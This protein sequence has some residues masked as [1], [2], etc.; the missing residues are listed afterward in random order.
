MPS[1]LLE[2]PISVKELYGRMRDYR[3]FIFLTVYLGLISLTV[4]FLYYVQTETYSYSYNRFNPNAMQELGKAIFAGVFFAELLL[5]NLVS[6]G[7]TSNAITAERERRTLDLLKITLLTPRSIITGKLLPSVVY[8]LL[9]VF[10][11]LPIQSAAFLLGGV[12]LAE[13]I[14]STLILIV[15]GVYLCSLGIFLSSGIKKSTVATVISYASIPL[16]ILLAFAVYLF[17][18]SS[19]PP[20]DINEKIFVYGLWVFVSINPFLAAIISELILVEADSLYLF[21]APPISSSSTTG[22]TLL[23]PWIIYLILYV[24]LSILLIMASARLVARPEK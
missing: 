20:D 22:Y 3:T 12:G 21:F 15:T 18:Q 9:L 19:G 14:I 1:R 4:G 8:I 2:N 13:F 11:A 24:I 7:L 6:P 17:V 5:I 16:T 23:S 10:T